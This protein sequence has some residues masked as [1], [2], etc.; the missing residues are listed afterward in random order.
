MSLLTIIT[1][2]AKPMR[3]PRGRGSICVL[4]VSSASVATL[5]SAN[6]M[7]ACCFPSPPLPAELGAIWVS[8]NI[9]EFTTH[10][11]P[12]TMLTSEAALHLAGRSSTGESLAPSTLTSLPRLKGKQ[13]SSAVG[14]ISLKAPGP[15]TSLIRS[16]VKFWW[17]GH[18]RGETSG[19]RL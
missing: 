18:C 16:K 4:S 10:L 19:V 8:L 3:E 2:S 1:K 14:L 12:S 15:R 7:C 17:V 6:T 9:K 11:V 5:P 13:H